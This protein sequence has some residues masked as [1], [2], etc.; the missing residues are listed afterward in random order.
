MAHACRWMASRGK[1]PL[2]RKNRV[3]WPWSWYRVGPGGTQRQEVVRKKHRHA[4]LPRILFDEMPPSGAGQSTD[5]DRWFVVLRHYYSWLHAAWCLALGLN[6]LRRA[7][8]IVP[9]DLVSHHKDWN[10]I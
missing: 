9:P 1:Y 8:D 7:F 3:K 5:P 4:V 10:T 6:D 2:R